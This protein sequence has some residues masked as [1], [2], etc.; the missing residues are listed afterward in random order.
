MKLQR[1]FSLTRQAVDRYHMIDEGDHIAVGL[2]GGKDSLTLLYALQGLMKF[3]PKKFTIT[4]VTVDL[5]FDN[6]DLTPVKMLCEQL[7]VPYTIV[8]T[9]IGK[10]LFDI[11]KE[12][13][14][15]ALCAKMRKGAF[16]KAAKD[17]GCNKVAYA[18]HKDDLVETMLLS[19]IYEGRFYAFSPYTYLDKMDLTV[20][21]PLIYVSEADVVGFK[22]RYDLPVCKN[23]CPVDGHTKREYVKILTNRIEHEN[24]GAKDRMFHAVL[25]GK[26][27]GWPEELFI[28]QG[29]EENE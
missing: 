22:N 9:D 12:T 14:P 5:G 11:R 3:Y 1:L 23:P 28:S 8:S 15:C 26:I 16:N 13:N 6:F 24:H 19:L 21:R 2:S 17:L 29:G 25:N 20:I 4:A 27:N 10:I 18:H 7:S